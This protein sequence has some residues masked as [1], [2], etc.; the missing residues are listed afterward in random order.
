[1]NHSITTD[2][3]ATHKCCAS[4]ISHAFDIGI[5]TIFGVH[6][7][8]LYSHFHYWICHNMMKGMNQH[9]GRTWTYD[10]YETLS[11]YLPY[12]TPREIG[13]AIQRLVDGGLLLKGN[14]SKNKFDKTGW[15]AFA[16]ED[17]VFSKKSFDTAKMSDRC[18]KSEASIE[19]PR[20]IHSTPTLDVYNTDIDTDI[21]NS[22]GGQEKHT[23]SIPPKFKKAKKA[24][25]VPKIAYRDLVTLTADEHQKLLDLYGDQ[26][27]QWMFDKLNATKASTGRQYKS[28]YATLCNGGWVPQAYDEYVNKS[29]KTS[30]ATTFSPAPPKQVDL[31]VISKRKHFVSQW[32]KQNWARVKD[33]CKSK[34]LHWHN[35]SDYVQ[36]GVDKTFYDSPTFDKDLKEMMKK[37]NLQ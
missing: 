35:G 14:F 9:E 3:S 34:D 21:D 7:A 36:V 8:I 37:Y 17:S 16:Q 33:I 26:K 32:E 19:R 2:N 28:D 13:L 12:L 11:K 20:P 6:S 27:L 29:G 1:M 18:D 25:E 24:E 30:S 22:V 31:E 5:A 23:H 10:S 4:G 15:Y